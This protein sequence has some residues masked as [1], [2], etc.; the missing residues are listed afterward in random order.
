[1]KRILL[2]AV[3]A[4]LSI[5]GVSLAQSAGIPV[6][7]LGGTLRL[8]RQSLSPIVIST[9][10]VAGTVGEDGIVLSRALT[11]LTGLTETSSLGRMPF[12]AALRVVLLDGNTDDELRCA[13]YLIQG[14]AIDGSDISEAV[15]TSG[16]T[17]ISET[18]FYTTNVFA[19]VRRVSIGGCDSLGDSSDRILVTTSVRYGLDLPVRVDADVQ[20]ICAYRSTSGA[21]DCI[22]PSGCSTRSFTGN[23]RTSYIDVSSC[24][25]P[26]IGDVAYS[27]DDMD[28]AYIRFRAT[29][30]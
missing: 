12:P 3:I 21:P 13:R 16:G 19:H 6:K 26:N 2:P 27:L 23:V 11:S 14:Y 15:T 7:A 22:G 29:D 25:F 20:A 1:M 8:H 30:R 10:T 17:A 24:S 9:A 28:S 5:P 18:A 4:L